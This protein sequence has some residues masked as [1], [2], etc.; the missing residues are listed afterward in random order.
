MDNIF[1]TFKNDPMW[2]WSTD[3][4]DVE[5]TCSACQKKIKLESRF[6]KPLLPKKITCPYCDTVH[7]IQGIEDPK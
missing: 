2:F 1:R 7:E 3:L 4:C 5:M 6:I